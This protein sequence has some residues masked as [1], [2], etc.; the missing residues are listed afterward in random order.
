MDR[1]QTVAAA[2]TEKESIFIVSDVRR[3]EQLV[4]TV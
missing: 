4:F 3:R 2:A 1:Q